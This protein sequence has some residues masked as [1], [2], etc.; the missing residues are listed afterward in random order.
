MSDIFV[1]KKT[2]KLMKIQLKVRFHI[3]LSGPD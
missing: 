3:L 1:I 2:V